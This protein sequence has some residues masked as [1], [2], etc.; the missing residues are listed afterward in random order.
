MSTKMTTKERE[1]FLSAVHVAILSIPEPDR[2]P[3]AVPVW[4]GY[5]PGGDVWLITGRNS[6]KGKLL[7]AAQR[8]TLT[9]QTEEPPYRYVMVE[10][11]LTIGAADIE[12]HERPLARAYLGEEMGDAYTDANGGGD[13]ILVSIT[14]ERWLTGDYSKVDVTAS[15]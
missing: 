14:P 4:Y 15:A 8:A 10:G 5:D 13:N 1:A 7:Q 11:P 2:G 12:T 6:M 9:V 3:L